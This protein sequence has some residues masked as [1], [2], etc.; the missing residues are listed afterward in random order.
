VNTVGENEFRLVAPP[1]AATI[2]KIGTLTKRGDV[3]KN[4][5]KRY[6]VAL[7]EANNFEILYYDH[8]VKG[9]EF[10]PEDGKVN[11]P[12]KGLK[13]RIKLAGYSVTKMQDGVGIQLEGNESQRPWY[14]KAESAQDVAEWMPIFQRAAKEA[15]PPQD[16]DPVVHAAFMDAYREVR[17]SQS[18]WGS[19]SVW[20]AEE[21][22]L[23]ELVNEIVQRRVMSDVYDAVP[24][25]PMKKQMEGFIK[26]TVNGMVRAGASATWKTSTTTIS[27]ISGPMRTAGQ[28][29][30]GPIA[31]QE[32]Q[33]VDK[34]VTA[35]K[36]LI[37]PAIEKFGEHAKKIFEVIAAPIAEFFVCAVK[38]FTKVMAAQTSNL[39]GDGASRKLSWIR[40]SVWSHNSDSMLMA[41][42]GWAADEAFRALAA[43]D[44]LAPLLGGR[45]AASLAFS[46]TRSVAKLLEKAVHDVEMQIETGVGA[47]PAISTTTGK[48]VNDCQL[49]VETFYLE[50]LGGI[51]IEPVNENITPLIQE[52]LA[53]LN[54]LIPEDLKD[55]FDL[56]RLAGKVVDETLVSALQT[57]V[58]P[59][60]DSTKEKIANAG[61]P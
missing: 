32:P 26:K 18:L 4:W 37:M 24:S 57:I 15:S 1:P 60:L 5:L 41:G 8:E 48:L 30:L 13:G 2:I 21:D 56:Q 38:G 58:A 61:N 35:I 39:A 52:P 33:M 10:E 49:T 11:P 34:I 36:G 31:E 23:G 54:E 59:A 12:T 47:V 6:F 7:N 25:G 9:E 42:G 43:I 55:F 44:A 29:V 19:W 51:I 27:Q 46:T 3:K 53:P 20:G 28:A 50:L 17:W 40:S 45:D 22:M 16:E 14:F